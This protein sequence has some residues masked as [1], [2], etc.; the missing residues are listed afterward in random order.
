MQILRYNRVAASVSMFFLLFSPACVRVYAISLY[1]LFTLA[2]V[3]FI[4]LLSF[5]R[6]AFGRASQCVA[7]K[8]L[9]HTLPMADRMLVQLLFRIRIVRAQL[10]I[11]SCAFVI[12][13][14]QNLFYGWQ[15]RAGEYRLWNNCG[16]KFSV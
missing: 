9:V 14:A 2:C 12:L 4:L 3:L 8:M 6:S 15:N 1:T 7:K 10:C 13:F 11:V 16:V 5:S